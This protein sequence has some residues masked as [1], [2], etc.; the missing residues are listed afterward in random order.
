MSFM[1]V[2]SGLIGIMTMNVHRLYIAHNIHTTH[3]I[4]T[5]TLAYLF[6]I[7]RILLLQVW[8]GQVYIHGRR[9]TMLT[10]Q[11]VRGSSSS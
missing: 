11:H 3:Y 1:A 5:I 6:I 9:G 10:M 7:Y 2:S 4:T 8:A